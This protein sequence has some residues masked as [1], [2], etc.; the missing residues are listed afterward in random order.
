MMMMMRMK[1]GNPNVS[2]DILCHKK[3]WFC[4][5]DFVA[6]MLVLE[7]FI[8]TDKKFD[9]GKGLKPVEFNTFVTKNKIIL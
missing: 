9:N 8:I 4:C 2:I 6:Q 7:R 3:N 5:I 1:L